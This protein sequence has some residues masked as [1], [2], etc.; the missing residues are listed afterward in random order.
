VTK[1]DRLDDLNIRGLAVTSDTADQIGAHQI[2]RIQ[3]LDMSSLEDALDSTY[4][5]FVSGES[6]TGK[7]TLAKLLS[8]W[9]KGTFFAEDV[10]Y[11]DSIDD[12]RPQISALYENTPEESPDLKGQESSQRNVFSGQPYSHGKIV[13]LDNIES[14]D[15]W[16]QNPKEPKRLEVLKQVI[17]DL[18]AANHETRILVFTR[19]PLNK[20]LPEFPD[21]VLLEMSLPTLNEAF[22]MISF[23]PPGAV[24]IMSENAAEIEDVIKSHHVNLLFTTTFLPLVVQTGLPPYQLVEKL[25]DEPSLCLETF[26]AATSKRDSQSAFKVASDRILAWPLQTDLACRMILPFCMFQRRFPLDA[27]FWLYKLL[28]TGA[29]SGCRPRVEPYAVETGNIHDWDL[30]DGWESFPPEWTFE[31]SFNKVQDCL[32][33]LGLLKEN[34]GSADQRGVDSYRIHPL[35]PYFLRSE[36]SKLNSHFRNPMDYQ[37]K[38]RQTF[39]EYYEIQAV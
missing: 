4:V 26:N 28:E 1:Q 8:Q 10:H 32:V 7:S 37:L 13:L 30:A 5:V 2:T 15:P 31:E 25:L 34:V 29:F 16:P 27:R 19:L 11:F 39:W 6:G 23:V 22:S 12:I 33:S 14:F 38:L 18:R 35:L 9:W 17:A 21:L 36:I 3:D 24:N 20:L